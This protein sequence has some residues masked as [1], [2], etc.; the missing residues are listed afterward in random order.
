MDDNRKYIV[1]QISTLQAALSDLGGLMLILYLLSSFFIS[2]VQTIAYL[3][4]FIKKFYV[5]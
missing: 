2:R 4:T 5:Y 3:T 1:R